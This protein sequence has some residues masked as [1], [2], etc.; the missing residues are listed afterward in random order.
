MLIY[1]VRHGQTDWNKAQR[2]QGRSDV[3]LNQTGRKQAH[4]VQAYFV[5][6]NITPSAVLSSPMRRA[7]AT[8]Q[9]IAEAVEQEVLPE[10][11]FREI[12][13]GD[14]EGKTTDE[15]IARYGKCFEDWLA[16]HHLVASPGGENIEQAITRIKDTLNAHIQ[17]FGDQ[18]VIVA[19]QAIMIAM[20]AALSGDLALT[21]LASYK[22]ANH[23]ID[24]WDVDRAK[25]IKRIDI[26]VG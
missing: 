19:H 5:E 9:G 24:V 3:E 20:K 17:Q 7:L 22:Q 12:N 1:F 25:I 2:W 21:T 16:N 14:F 26:R 23:E 8:A 18:L 15:L 10:Q 11:A 13:L 6:H 4:A